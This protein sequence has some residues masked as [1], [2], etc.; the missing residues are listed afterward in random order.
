MNW[1]DR[2]FFGITKRA[3]LLGSRE[4][5]KAWYS[6]AEMQS[7]PCLYEGELMPWQWFVDQV[8]SVD[9]LDEIDTV[10]VLNL[11]VAA[12]EDDLLCEP[13]IQLRF[14]YLLEIWLVGNDLECVQR[15][16]EVSMDLDPGYRPIQRE[17]LMSL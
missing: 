16:N 6:F 13:Y 15:W 1:G 14:E 5:L 8:E 7:L 11:A 17:V 9:Y 3:S 12:V 2:A 4:W 10:H